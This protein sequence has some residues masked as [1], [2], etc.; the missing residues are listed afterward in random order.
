MNDRGPATNTSWAGGRLALAQATLA[1]LS[2][3]CPLFP[4][5]AHYCPIYLLQGAVDGVGAVIKRKA[6]KDREGSS[7]P[8]MFTAV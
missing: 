4:P 8:V 2:F 1:L 3:D 6:R 7:C 5:R